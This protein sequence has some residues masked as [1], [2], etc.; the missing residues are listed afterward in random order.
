M[1]AAVKTWQVLIDFSV[2]RKTKCGKCRVDNYD[3]YSCTLSML[4]VDLP[5]LPIPPFRIPNLYID[6]SHVELGMDILLPK[7]NFVPRSI[8]MPRLPDLPSPPTINLNLDLNVAIPNIPQIPA[9]PKLPDLP[10]FIPN[11][12]LNLPSLPPAP[13]L[14][15]IAPQIT[16][17]LKVA[18]VIAKIFCIVK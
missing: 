2:N 5:V 6:L 1:V 4:C 11:V 15:K 16:A 18:E 12:Q 17:S 9:P 8:P 10:S 3:F 13:R 14:P 7:F